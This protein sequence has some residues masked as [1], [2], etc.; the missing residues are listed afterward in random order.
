MPAPMDVPL[1]AGQGTSSASQ[2]AALAQALDDAKTAACATLLDACYDAF[3]DELS[4]L[5]SA[6]RDALCISLDD[7][8]SPT[9]LLHLRHSPNALSSATA[10][11]PYSARG[12]PLASN[13]SLFLVQT[14]R[15]LRVVSADGAGRSPFRDALARC[16]R[17]GVVGF[18][19]G[20]LAA[21]VVASSPS[22]GAFIAN[23]ADAMRVAVWIGVRAMQYQLRA[24]TVED[25]DLPWSIVVLGASRDEMEELLRVRNQG[26]AQPVTLFPDSS[27]LYVTAVLDDA[28]VTVSGRPDALDAFAVELESEFVVHRTTLDAL[29]HAPEHQDGALKQVLADICR[30]RVRFPDFADLQVPIRSTFTGDAV[31][32]AHNSPSLAEL[33]LEMVLTQCVNWDRVVAGIAQDVGDDGVRLVNFGPGRAL[34]RTTERALMPRGGDASL[35]RTQDHTTAKQEAIAIVGM[36]IKVPGVTDAGALW[37]LLEN[38]VNTVAEI[39]EHRFKVEDYNG[40]KFVGRQLKA[41]SG[42]FLDNVDEFDNVFF[43]ISPREARSMDP[44]QRL[45]LHTAYEA[46]EDAG[47]VPNATPCFAPE[48]FGCYIGAATGDYVQNL[49]DEVDVYYSTGTLR[50]FLSGRIS[51]AMQL[52]GPS[53]VVDTAC[54]SSNVALYL[55]ARALMNGDCNAALVGG[56]NT[57][58]SPDMFLG[59]DRGHF[60]SPT[61]QCTAFD[62]SADGYSRAGGCGLFVLK[63]LKDAEAENDRI[64]AV[65]RGVEANQSGLAH[66]ITYPHAATQATL[67]HKVL[68]TS[69]F[70]PDRINV[71]EAHGTGTQAGDPNEVASL[72]SVLCAGGRP[73]GNP[74]YITSVK[75]NVG[76]LEA[77]SGA[78]GLAKLLLMLQHRA[79]PAQISYRTRNP[80]IR[81]LEED[82]TVIPQ[83]RCEWNPAVEGLPRV[84][85]LNNF[86]AAGSNTAVV[87]E[88]Y[89]SPTSSLSD[90]ETTFVFGLS[91]KTSTA[92]DALRVKYL[93]WLHCP[94]SAAAPLANIAY[95]MTARRQIHSHRV[96]VAASSRMELIDKLASLAIPSSHAA[97]PPTSN[98]I[99][100]FSGQGSQYFGMGREIYTQNM[101]FRSCVD[102]CDRILI[103][104]GFPGVLPI[105]LAT[106]NGGSGL[107]EMKEIEA[108][109]AAIFVLECALARVWIGLGEYAALV[110]AGVLSLNHALLIV[111][112]R[113]RLIVRNCALGMSG[114]IAVNLS[115]EAME[116]ILQ[117]GAEEMSELSIAC[118]NTPTDCVL[119][120]PVAQLEA[121]KSMLDATSIK[122][123]ILPLPF[124]YH[125][126]AMAPILDALT[127]LVVEKRFKLHP[128]TIPVVSNVLGDVVLPGDASVFTPAYFA[129]HCA[130]PV[131]FERGVRALLGSLSNADVFIELGPH[132]TCLPML[133][134]NA[135]EA[136]VLPS[137]RRQQSPL[138][139]LAS[140]LASVWTSSIGAS[141]N[142]RSVFSH[143]PSVAPISL[144]SYPF[145]KTK[146]WV[147][148]KEHATAGV[149]PQQSSSDILQYSLLDHWAQYPTLDNGFVAVFETPIDTLSRAITGHRVGGL[150]LCPASV[151][152]ELALAGVELRGQRLPTKHHDSHVFLRALE[153][154]N[155]LVYNADVSRTVVTRIEHGTFSVGSRVDGSA[156]ELV[157]ARGEFEYGPML[158]MT[159]KFV[160]TLPVIAEHI[161]AVG[162]GTSEVFSKRTTYEVI[163]PRVVEYGEEYHTIQTLTVSTSGM[164]GVATVQLPP[165]YD[166]ASFVVHPVWMDTLLHVAGFV[167]N[168]QGG[169]N[170]AYICTR[171]DAVKVF[172]GVVNNDKPYLVYCRN[173]WLED[174]GVIVAESYAVQ[175]AEPRRI[176]AHLKGIH[177][178]RVRL[179][180]LR[181]SLSQA[182]G[183]ESGF[184]VLQDEGASPPPVVDV[185]ALV[186]KLVAEACSV[187]ISSVGGE[188]DLASLGVDSLMFIEICGSLRTAFPGIGP[189]LR[190]VSHCKTVADLSNEVIVK[191]RSSPT[192]S[193]TPTARTRTPQTLVNDPVQLDIL[194]TVDALPTLAKVLGLAADRMRSDADLDALGLDSL[195]AIEALYELKSQF[196]VDLPRDFFRRYKTPRD[197]QEYFTSSKISTA[198]PSPGTKRISKTLQL[199]VVPISIQRANAS[200]RLPL[201]LIHDGSGLVNYYDR[202][203]FL[204]R[205]IWGIPNPRFVTGQPWSELVDMA[206]AY[207]DYILTTTSG[208]LL[209][210]GWSFGGVVAYEIA[211]QLTARGVH[212]KGII[213]IDAPSPVNH[214]PL[215]E[216]IIDRVLQLDAP[217]SVELAALVRK[218]FS[219]NAQI[220]GK[221]VPHATASLCPALVLLRSSEGVHFDDGAPDH[222]PQW[223]SERSDPQTSIAGWQSLAHCSVKV[224][225]IS[226]NHFETF[227]PANVAEVSL[228]IA[229]ACEYLESI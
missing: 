194:P 42:N 221:Y 47:Y 92:L 61:G 82:G 101:V 149:E 48:T 191:L 219:N 134:A 215:P 156:D 151:H 148:F 7:F 183:R 145:A 8:P 185:E 45:L 20:I 139:T 115:P 210:G 204:D 50:A 83:A 18:S 29:Y 112:H 196:G 125:G 141:V 228:R 202:L 222:V 28:S 9:S 150:P 65:I 85:M 89:V 117:S 181:R 59:L 143:V 98:A 51:F 135:V 33:V 99:F 62:A 229:D 110:T 206:A 58:S 132:P 223:L 44:Q 133:K 128:P 127:M 96:A 105:I 22:L 113:A 189:A 142:W 31:F 94:E 225:D 126:P 1:F 160:Q 169:V 205:D 178:R 95:T 80:L 209:L 77:A 217:R 207:V 212:V 153:F 104:A 55:G 46:L 25:A 173:A 70:S 41:R 63:R 226:G 37:R 180:G 203:S 15:Y 49:K 119:S 175:V 188:S 168:M 40:A 136:V 118:Y 67:F 16:G 36:A 69:G 2:A 53:M 54:S 87:L 171:I 184:K 182:A 129:R 144:P 24:G 38:G 114:M 220:L 106:P 214:V 179:S 122:S 86:G 34:L 167:A 14:L 60:L 162:E 71:V 91:A 138:T 195:S 17:C 3:H 35:D 13:A 193:L 27:P 84:A 26:L 97:T 68:Q 116:G 10:R 56:V 192:P 120:G 137:M 108:C 73:A 76:H 121:L 90:T 163:F 155:P 218:Q 78:A 158:R 12:N 130:E 43:N 111:A 208:P 154:E 52:G 79:I 103:N 200:D 198:P 211:L 11:T 131:Q 224:L 166:R 123:T 170:D 57:I 74:L 81:P 88:E 147:P 159:T 100:M 164:E 107:S 152:L 75:A 165:D 201:F 21:C 109:Q 39:P 23:A 102:E 64:L 174:E 227:H 190:C 186:T 177:F 197:V 19:S 72:R 172:P 176:V 6:E 216:S 32:H 213:L 4:S 5:S 124:G 161:A 66:S 199:D 140:S 93:D 157:H 30:R 146:F 187:A